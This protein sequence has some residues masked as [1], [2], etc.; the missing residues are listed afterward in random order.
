MPRT[1]TFRRTGGAA[2]V[3]AAMLLLAAGAAALALH[4]RAEARERAEAGSRALGNAFALTFTAAHR[5]SQFRAAALRTRLAASPDGFRLTAAELRGWGFLPP[6]LPDD[7]RIRVGIAADPSVPPGAPAL[8]M[9]V[10]LLAAP[11]WQ[12]ARE[13]AL[14]AGLAALGSTGAPGPLDARRAAVETALGAAAGAGDLWVSADLGLGHRETVLHR[15][16]Q[17]GRPGLS[18]METALDMNGNAVANAGALA[19]RSLTA[20]PGSAV[21]P[22]LDV[23]TDATV[24]G[25]PVPAGDPGHLT[26]AGHGLAAAGGVTV[27]AGT[28]LRGRAN[29]A[30]L[31][32]PGAL[33]AASGTSSG[34]AAAA[35]AT[36]S[37]TLTARL[38]SLT[39]ARRVTV[40]TRLAAG[41]AQ[42]GNL[43]AGSCSGC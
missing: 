35:S 18:R 27:G 12:P 40:G 26:S 6:G 8:P 29:A 23:G 20:D 22:A 3:L 43:T 38:L 17:P 11:A 36:A 28:A 42:V 21:L 15:L 4:Y 2:E 33:T 41:W 39:G 31:T 24:S 5:A 32:V 25:A 9:A 37:G 10:G 30:S 19:A 16:P 14:S 1:R 34:A 7:A 13:G